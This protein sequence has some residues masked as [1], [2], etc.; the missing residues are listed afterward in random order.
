MKRPQTIVL[1]CLFILSLAISSPGL[2]AN[3]DSETQTTAE[4]AVVSAE[5]P[6][7]S[8]C[9]AFCAQVIEQA[10]V[11]KT[12]INTLPDL[13]EVKTSLVDLEATIKDISQQVSE[14]VAATDPTYDRIF[15]LKSTVIARE[16]AFDELT[17]PIEKSTTQLESWKNEWQGKKDRLDTFKNRLSKMQPGSAARDSLARAQEVTN[18]SLQLISR[19]LEKV[20]AVQQKGATIEA[21]IH[22]MKANLNAMLSA[23]RGQTLQK[24][25]PSLLSTEYVA[26]FERSLWED[27]V[28]GIASVKWPDRQFWHSK[29]WLLLL[30]VILAMLIATS[31]FRNRHFI[32]K[33]DR[34]R[35]LIKR[36]L[37]AGLFVSIWVVGPFYGVVDRT[38]SFLLWVVAGVTAARLVGGLTPDH[39]KRF[40]VYVLVAI[41]IFIQLCRLIALPVPLFRLCIFLIALWGVAFCA[42]ENIKVGRRAGPR[43]FRWGFR[44][45]GLVFISVTLLELAG[46]HILAARLL[47]SSLKT[48]LLILLGWMF[49]VLLEGWVKFILQTKVLDGIPRFRP[50]AQLIEGRLTNILSVFVFTFVAVILLVVW[51]VYENV[52]DALQ[53]LFSIGFSVGT[54]KLTLGMMIIVAIALYVSFVVSWLVQGI[55]LEKVFPRR[56]VQLGVQMSMT[57]LVH[58]GI[59][60]VGFLLAL[61]FLGVDMKNITIIGGALG[62]GIGFGL[63]SIVS[64]F[65]SGLILLFERPI[66]AGDY[67][68]L[69]ERWGEVSRVGLRST[70]VKTFDRSE[71]VVP[72]S[73]LISNEVTNWTLS[74]RS[75]RLRLSVGVAYGSDIDKVIATLEECGR[76]NPTVVSNPP[77]QVLFMKFGES[78]LD[79]ELRVWVSDIDNMVVARSE[80]NQE[81][82]RTFRAAG[83]EIAFPQ[84]DL[85][86]R[87]IEPSA[88]LPLR[89]IPNETDSES[90]TDIEKGEGQKGRGDE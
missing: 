71:V 4:P 84:R 12:N 5:K 43:L 48:V 50:N 51:R 31:I 36:P 75:I 89:R 87:S 76:D 1:F 70:I 2:G 64:N 22:A 78:C 27:F 73:N 14:L 47:E 29:G 37:S 11:L 67:V 65:V 57:R 13:T 44:L 33:V 79:F 10:S 34:W 81:I 46:Y 58:Y 16:K 63:Q 20:L 60:F 68:Q 26:K 66:K 40:G 83:I 21:R 86:L 23:A 69:G 49:V 62:V 17:A 56:R 85:H 45:A 8:E 39:R 82:D 32:E 15:Q 19:E 55:L 61:S 38:W 54:W 28:R 42:W 24:S 53:G 35:F 25:A 30:Q 74:D 41:V 18:T 9:I 3:K 90:T 52:G 59:I 77:P 7:Q 80:I 72:N 6:E 88:A